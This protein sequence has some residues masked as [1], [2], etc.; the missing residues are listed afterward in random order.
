MNRICLCCGKPLKEASSSTWHAACI[1][2]FFGGKEIPSF[3]MDEIIHEKLAEELI[4]NGESVTGVQKKL[5]I[6]LSSIRKTL[7]TE[8]HFIIKT[9]S[10]DRPLLPEWEF[11][12]M[13]LAEIIGFKTV[14][15]GLIESTSKETIY[16][17]KRIDRA[18]RNGKTVKLPM[19][20]FAQLSETQTEYKYNGSY[21]RCAKKVIDRF[22]STSYLD[23]ILLF[24]MV[25]FSFIIGNTDMHLKN[26]SLIKTEGTYSLSPFYD[27]LPVLMVV[28]QKEMAL[29][30]NGKNQ[31]LTQNDF[32]AFAENIEI[33]K[34][35]ALSAM[36]S[37]L[38]KHES[39][40][41]F[42]KESPV[43]EEKQDAL[44]ALIKERSA[45]FLS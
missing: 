6:T 2:R 10:K 31:K 19:E 13:K 25:F 18:E 21:E 38:G 44:I 15:N 37:I 41:S 28:D 34:G 39:L 36:K 16:I 14:P 1:K 11:I 26:F 33:P 22:S 12:G 45:P 5:S 43:P 42:I 32:L 35:V 23:K 8:N 20:D 29:T 40:Y 27:I 30:V 3:D 24:K 9:A 4:E 7:I 17:T